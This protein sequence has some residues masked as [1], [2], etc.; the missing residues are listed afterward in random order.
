MP[1]R[2]TIGILGIV[3][4]IFAWNWW[5]SSKEAELEQWATQFAHY[6]S[7]GYLN[8]EYSREMEKKRKAEEKRERR[9]KKKEQLDQPETPSAEDS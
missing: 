1:D 3:V 9:R 6:S 2:E 8:F 4:L 7:P 5:R